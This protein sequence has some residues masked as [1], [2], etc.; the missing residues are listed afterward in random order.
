M[1][2]Q[3]VQDNVMS[4][5]LAA[6]HMVRTMKFLR[7]L[8]RGAEVLNSSFI[9]TCLETGKVPDI[10]DHK[11]KDTENEK[12]F[13]VSI[14]T[15]VARARQNRGRLL[16]GV[17]IYCTAD[18]KNGVDSYKTI[19]EAN[20]AIFK[21]YRARSG[22][23][24][25]PTTAEEDGNAP[26]EP[27]YLLTSPSPAEKLLWPKFEEMAKNGNMEPRIVVSDWLLDVAMKQE[28]SFDPKYLAA[29]YFAENP[30]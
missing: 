14:E 22:T 9:T 12:R 21:I 27:V 30:S 8:A 15:A 25:K 23:T 6:P 4:D 11:L 24:I 13:G 19:A 28:L 5:Y 10:E 17:P 3:I 7:C 29:R 20:G 1:G 2:V 16:W 18:I 26:P